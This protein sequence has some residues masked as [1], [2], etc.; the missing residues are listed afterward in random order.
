MKNSAKTETSAG[1]V[2]SPKRSIGP[3]WARSIPPG[4]SPNA[5]RS[6]HHRPISTTAE[7]T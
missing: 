6:A 5:S 4:R 1:T 7:A 2:G 3:S